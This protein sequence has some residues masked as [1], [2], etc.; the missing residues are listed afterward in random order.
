MKLTGQH[1]TVHDQ[2]DVDIKAHGHLS[3]NFGTIDTSGCKTSA[4][5]STGGHGHGFLIPFIKL[6]SLFFTALPFELIPSAY[7]QHAS[8]IKP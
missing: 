7:G 5:Q 3:S 4:E 2:N 1:Y 8:S 6:H